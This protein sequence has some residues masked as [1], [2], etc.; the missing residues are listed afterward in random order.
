[1]KKPVRGSMKLNVSPV[2]VALPG[3]TLIH[4]RSLYQYPL[5]RVGEGS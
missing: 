2:N 3:K 4:W 1:M 5:V